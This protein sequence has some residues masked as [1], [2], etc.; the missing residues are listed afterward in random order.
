MNKISIKGC[1]FAYE[2]MGTGIPTVVLET[3]IGAESSEWGQSHPSSRDQMPCFDTTGQVGGESTPGQGNLDAL[4]MVDELNALLE[5]TR[6][7]GPYL[8]VGHSF[9]VF[10][11]YPPVTSSQAQGWQQ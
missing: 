5:A 1:Q 4:T 3:G 2:V 11:A 9:G 6:T 10:V 7:E 8:L